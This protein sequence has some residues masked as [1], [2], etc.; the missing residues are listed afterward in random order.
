MLM[1]LIS[2][3]FYINRSQNHE[4]LGYQRRSYRSSVPKMYKYPGQV[5]L[6]WTFFFSGRMNKKSTLWSTLTCRNDFLWV[7]FLSKEKKKKVVF[8]SILKGIPNPGTTKCF[9][10][11]LS[12]SC[13]EW[14]TYNDSVEWET[15]SPKSQVKT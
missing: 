13:F 14:I 9:V 12:K 4:F 3:I 5:L 8:V 7:F 10:R 15:S 11:V 6:W 1:Y 2:S